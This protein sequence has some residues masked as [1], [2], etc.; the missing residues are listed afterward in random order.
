MFSDKF[1][2]T[3]SATF[4]SA[5]PTLMP[6]HEALMRPHALSAYPTLTAT[7]ALKYYLPLTLTLVSYVN[8]SVA[9][10]TLFELV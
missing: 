6:C 9:F 1:T 10:S 8:L 5:Y 2:P 7:L 3:D 4:L